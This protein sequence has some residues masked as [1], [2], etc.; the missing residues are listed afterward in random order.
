MAAKT[1]AKGLGAVA[2]IVTLAIAIAYWVAYL[3]LDRF[4]WARAVLW[5]DADVSDYTRFPARQI[6]AGSEAYAYAKGQG[7]PDG[8]SASVRLPGGAALDDFL[9]AHH[10]TAFLVIKDDKLLY[11]RYFN[12]S[13]H[14]AVQTSFSVAKSFN[15]AMIGAALE[16]GSLVGTD[17]PI[18][19]Y[20]PELAARDDRFTRITIRHLA[21]MSSGI[22]YEEHGLPWS[23]DALTYY[24]PDLRRLALDTTWIEEPPGQ[25]FHYNNY[26]PLLLGIILERAT[27]M[28]IADY[29]SAKIWKPL[30]AEADASWSLDS[31]AN[32]FE[33][34]ES[35]INARAI[36]FAKLG[37]LYLHRGVF[38]GH[39]ILPEAWVDMSTTPVLPTGIGTASY[40]WWWWTGHDP[41]LGAFYSAR[42]N[43]GQFVFVFPA[44]NLVI[45]RNGNAYGDADW[46]ALMIAVAM[47]S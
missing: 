17:D 12:G 45:V 16:D 20:L 29:L 47:A 44:K 30:G 32:G 31:T 36:D 19:K 14:D 26:N 8:L 28:H 46:R 6:A 39:R 22:H 3:N 13:S 7:Y 4:A 33:K 5:M 27:G 11:E 9:E 1:V 43:K 41:E 42:G 25:R 38:N 21:T 23:D 35:G 10:T 15:S 40:A 34:M 18:T 2:L 37:S 24:S